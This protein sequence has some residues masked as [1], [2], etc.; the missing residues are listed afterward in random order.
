[1]MNCHPPWIVIFPE[2][3]RLFG[4]EGT[5]KLMSGCRFLPAESSY[6]AMDLP[7]VF[8][9]GNASLICPVESIRSC[10]VF[11]PRALKQLAPAD[12]SAPLLGVISEAISNEPEMHQSKAI[13][14]RVTPEAPNAKCLSQNG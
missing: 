11:G 10:D 1:M 4:V 14:L 13:R 7:A 3:L 6:T 2:F 12:L 9:V 5:G 8:T